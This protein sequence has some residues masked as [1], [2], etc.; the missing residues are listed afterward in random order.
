M[1]A[2]HVVIAI[3]ALIGVL[4]FSMGSPAGAI[5][6]PDYTSPPP[7]TVVTPPTPRSVQRVQTAVTVRPVRSQLAIT[8]SDVSQLV[9]IGGVLVA[10]G[11][12][13]L[14]V[15]RRAAA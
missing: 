2:R 1:R 12:G 8:G 13:M 4:V 10:V 6:N 3:A 15:R 5:D 7:T 14:V 11:A 9:V